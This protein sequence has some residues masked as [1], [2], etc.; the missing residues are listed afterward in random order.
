MRREKEAGRRENQDREDRQ[1]QSP[2]LRG[3]RARPG[4]PGWKKEAGS[5]EKW[6]RETRTTRATDS[7]LVP[8]WKKAGDR[9]GPRDSET[10]GSRD[11]ASR[12]DADS[13]SVPGEKGEGR[14][15]ENQPGAAG[16]VEAGMGPSVADADARQPRVGGRRERDLE[17]DR[18]TERDL[19]TETES[20]RGSSPYTST[21]T[22]GAEDADLRRRLPGDPNDEATPLV[23]NPGWDSGPRFVPMRQRR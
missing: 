11:G 13:G 16:L 9:Q 22:T 6:D 5:R 12:S 14:R 18:G 21:G 19:D 15:R 10:H 8:G 4:R 17:S 7:G 20:E 2:E 1:M 3:P 23:G